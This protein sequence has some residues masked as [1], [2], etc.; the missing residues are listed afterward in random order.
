VGFKFIFRRGAI[1]AMRTG[2]L[3]G[4]D[5]HLRVFVAIRA[6]QGTVI[7]EFTFIQKFVTIWVTLRG[8]SNFTGFVVIMCGLVVGVTS[9]GF[10]V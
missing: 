7:A 10:F 2:E 5:M 6:V 8:I 9:G 1:V 3:S 4:I